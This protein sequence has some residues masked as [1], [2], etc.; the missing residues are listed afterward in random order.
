[1]MEPEEHWEIERRFRRVTV[2]LHGTASAGGDCRVGGT[3]SR[4]GA[5]LAG[6]L[7]EPG[8]GGIAG[9]RQVG[10]QPKPPARLATA[11][12]VTGATGRRELPHGGTAGA[13]AAAVTYGFGRRPVVFLKML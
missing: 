6:H 10:S 4:D 3:I 5:N 13:V 1:M 7:L 2:G 8:T 9:A 11:R 12:R